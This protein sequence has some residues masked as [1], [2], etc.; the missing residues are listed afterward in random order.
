M[1]HQPYQWNLE[2]MWLKATKLTKARAR[3]AGAKAGKQAWRALKYKQWITHTTSCPVGWMPYDDTYTTY[4]TGL[5]D[6][7]SKIEVFVKRGVS[8]RTR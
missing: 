2:A 1:L 3:P 4:H 5:Q 6:F 7:K 8:S